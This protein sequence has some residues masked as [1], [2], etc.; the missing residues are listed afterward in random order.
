MDKVANNQLLDKLPTS[1]NFIGRRIHIFRNCHIML[2]SDLAELYQV[3]TKRLNEAV[4]RN[5]GRFPED[6][7]FQL[8]K[9][10]LKNWRSQIATSNPATRMSLRRP[11]Y[12]FTEYGVVMLSSV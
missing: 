9:E 3:P 11:P 4:K 6:F 2:D 10:E 12:A 8:T 7:M 5:R 1:S